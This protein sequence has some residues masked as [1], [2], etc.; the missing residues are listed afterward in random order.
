MR[1]AQRLALGD[2]GEGIVVALW[3]AEL[4]RQTDY[5]YS[6]GRGKAMIAAARQRRWEV[7]PSPHLAYFTSAPEQRLY[8]APEL[9]AQA[10]AERWEGPDGRLIGQHSAEEVRQRLWPWL[11]ERGYASADD[12][13]VL[14]QFLTI[15][16]RRK[17]H[18]RPGMRFRCR[19]DRP[20]IDR[21]ATASFGGSRAGGRTMP[22]L[23]PSVTDRSQLRLRPSVKSNGASLQLRQRPGGSR[24]TAPMNALRYSDIGDLD[25]QLPFSDIYPFASCTH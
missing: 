1:S 7:R 24:G 5:L 3:P 10:Y 23:G 17:A 16:G 22:F 8:M 19:W 2:I 25:G 21:Q 18:L 4:K 13:E 11:K 6:E 20:E 9:D 12:D 15:L 14:E